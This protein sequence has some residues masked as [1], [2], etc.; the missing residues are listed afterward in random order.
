M[1]AGYAVNREVS[2][3][4]Q[5]GLTQDIVYEMRDVDEAREMKVVLEVRD[6][7]PYFGEEK[8]EHPHAHALIL[9]TTDN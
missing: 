5:T 6:S 8:E 1:H 7:D 9:I 4:I 2:F 3:I